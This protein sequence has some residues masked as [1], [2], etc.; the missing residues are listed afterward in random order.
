[1]YHE[2]DCIVMAL[3]FVGCCDPFFYV[4]LQKSNENLPVSVSHWFDPP[5]VDMWCAVMLGVKASKDLFCTLI[6]S[7]T[8]FALMT[9][10]FYSYKGQ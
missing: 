10:E 1:M 7:S 9:P 3:Y 6:V 8:V 2:S 4:C 5:C